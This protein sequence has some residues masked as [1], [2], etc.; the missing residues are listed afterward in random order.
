MYWAYLIDK[1]SKSQTVKSYVS[2]IKSILKAEKY[3]WNNNLILL[4]SLT[5]ACRII[6][7]KVYHRFPIHKGLLEQ[8]LFEC[9]Q[10][11]NGQP[12]LETLYK[13]VLLMGYYGLMRAGEIGAEKGDFCMNHTLK[14]KNVHIG[15]NKPKLLL[16]LYSSKTHADKSVPQKIKISCVHGYKNSPKYSHFCLFTEIR[17]YM[18]LRGSFSSDDEQFFIFRTKI[19][20]TPVH[21]RIVLKRLLCRIELDSTLYDFHSLHVRRATDLIKYGYSVEQVKSLG[22]WTS[23]AVYR[24]IKS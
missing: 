17:C 20:V 14:A 8:L 24:Y 15:Q 19:P 6:N 5:K 13:A 10:E 12:F 2:A 16:V 1:G 7:D 23:N 18:D 22:R 4:D 11:F 21:L 9:E 3:P